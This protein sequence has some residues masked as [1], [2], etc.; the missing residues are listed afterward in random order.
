MMKPGER[1]TIEDVAKRAGV[2]TATVS[3]VINR[4]DRV[5]EATV[6]RVQAAIDELNYHPS[7]AA[8]GLAARRTHTLGLV[9]HEIGDAFAQAMLRGIETTASANGYDLLLHTMRQA[10][11]KST[12]VGEHNTDGLIVFAD[13]LSPDELQQFG[14]FP[15]VLLHRSAPAGMPI[16][17]VNIEN[18]NGARQA[19][20]HLI[21]KCGRTRIAYLAGPPN[22]ED[23]YWRGQGYQD[24]L[25][26]HGLDFRLIGQGDFDIAPARATVQGWLADGI[27]F[28]AIFA[29]DDESAIGA[30]LA[31]GEAGVRV[32]EDVALVGFDDIRLAQ[33]L[34]PPLTTIR[35]PIE[36]AATEAVNQLLRLIQTGE[37]DP[38]TLLP[39]ELVIRQSCGFYLRK[40]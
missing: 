10:A 4:T 13:S 31:L 37:A 22:D 11:T 32:P 1:A 6:A 30:L 40:D 21:E 19:V 39:T 25:A 15:V 7:A 3:R 16:P 28:D 24:A 20:E 12:S 18:R 34:T 29:G 35:S 17:A 27:A 33:Y 9:L 8:R 23:S 36:A 26:A 5:S 38:V 2:S 14:G